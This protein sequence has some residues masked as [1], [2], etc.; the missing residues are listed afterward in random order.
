MSINERTIDLARSF[1]GTIRT[2]EDIRRTQ[3]V[4]RAIGNDGELIERPRYGSAWDDNH[5][6]MIGDVHLW[7]GPDDTW[8]FKHGKANSPT[9][10][11]ELN[12]DIVFTSTWNGDSPLKLGTWTVFIDPDGLLRIKNGTPADG[13][14]GAA[15]GAGI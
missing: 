10:G 15:V 13:Y 5:P 11:E 7:V 4:E 8:R 14:D 3:R 1:V 9:D 2:E 12:P 6:L